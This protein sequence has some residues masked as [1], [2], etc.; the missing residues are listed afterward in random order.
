MCDTA[1][2]EVCAMGKKVWDFIQT[3]AGID[4][5]KPDKAKMA[6]LMDVFVRALGSMTVAACSANPV[7]ITLTQIDISTRYSQAIAHA[8]EVTMASEAAQKP[9]TSAEAAKAAFD[10]LMVGS[11]H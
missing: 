6:A 2:C 7:A 5:E 9:A 10:G 3:E 1:T 11:K 4:P 8:Y